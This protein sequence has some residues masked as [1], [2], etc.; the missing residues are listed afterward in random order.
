MSAQTTLIL[1][2]PDCVS[3]GLCGEVLKR[4]ENAGFVIRG[5]KMI[6][7][8][9]EVLKDHYSHIADKPFFPEVANFMKSVPVIALALRGDNVIDRVRT[10]LGPTD[11]RKADKGTIRGDY[12]GDMM[13]NVAHASD[14]PENAEAELKRFFKADE[15]FDR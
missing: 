2:K 9:D 6:Q 1:L 15:L 8:T 3:K 11:S 13:V 14:S 5:L 4:F 7:L 12:G 10:L